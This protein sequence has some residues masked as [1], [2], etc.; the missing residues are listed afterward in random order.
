M[1]CRTRS[2]RLK[3]SIVMHNDQHQRRKE[4]SVEENEERPRSLAVGP[5]PDKETRSLGEPPMNRVKEALLL[6][7]DKGARARDISLLID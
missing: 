3:A 4:K 2:P 1:K 7:E 6:Q 5:A